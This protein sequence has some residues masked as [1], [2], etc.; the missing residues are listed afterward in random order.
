MS[1]LSTPLGTSS[2]AIASSNTQERGSRRDKEKSG[3]QRLAWGLVN[4]AGYLKYLGRYRDEYSFREA[5]QAIPWF[6][7]VLHVE[8][9]HDF[10]LYQ[11]EKAVTGIEFKFDQPTASVQQ[12]RA[13]IVK[14]F[15]K[16]AQ[17]PLSAK[18]FVYLGSEKSFKILWKAVLTPGETVHTPT[19]LDRNAATAALLENVFRLD[20]EIAKVEYC[21]TVYDV[22][23]IIDTIW[24]VDLY[25]YRA[26]IWQVL[27][28]G[29]STD[30]TT[31]NDDEIVAKSEVAR[32]DDDDDED[33]DN[34]DSA[35]ATADGSQ[36]SLTSLF[37]KMKLEEK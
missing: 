34:D 5:F 17:S 13:D 12:A 2:F 18:F 35:T 37:E 6:N 10:V 19:K 9:D 21:G 8:L 4:Y 25:A 22:V 29:G 24:E 15:G 14:D 3:I 36:R 26:V 32:D 23:P 33:D 1:Q 31:F 28:A 27:A 20:K 7:G 16:L 30:T 11:D